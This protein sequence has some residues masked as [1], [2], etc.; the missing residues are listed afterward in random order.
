MLFQEPTEARDLGMQNRLHRRPQRTDALRGLSILELTDRHRY[1][2]GHLIL[3]TPKCSLGMAG[4]G[5]QAAIQAVPVSQQGA[6]H[7]MVAMVG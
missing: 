5:G 1:S 2:A 7:N 3:R 6:D 4:I